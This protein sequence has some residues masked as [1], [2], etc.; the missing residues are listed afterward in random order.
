MFL[1]RL[2]N[3]DSNNAYV[4]ESFDVIARRQ[5]VSN[6][7]AFVMKSAALLI[8]VI[9]LSLACDIIVHV[10][11]DTDK[12]FGAQVTASNGKKS[13]RWTFTKKLKKTFQQKADECGLNDWEIV[14]FDEN[15]K[16][17]HDVK[18]TLDGIGRVEYV[19]GDDLKP[20]QKNRQGAICKGECAPLASAG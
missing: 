6:D 12:K 9:S 3:A 8:A 7:S 2:R 4:M 16:V 11:S 18:V 15:G 5:S 10:K 14:T 20:V 19:V 17:A 1:D 13:D